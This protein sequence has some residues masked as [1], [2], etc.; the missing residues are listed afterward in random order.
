MNNPMERE[1][2]SRRPRNQQQSKQGM[3]FVSKV[4]FGFDIFQVVMVVVFQS[5]M[6][7]LGN[8]NAYNS[9]EDPGVGPGRRIYM[10]LFMGAVVYTCFLCLFAVKQQNFMEILA[11]LLQNFGFVTYGLIQ[12]Y[13]V[14]FKKIEF[15]GRNA[16]MPRDAQLLPIALTNSLMLFLLNAVFMYLSWKL[17]SEFGWKIYK[18]VRF[19]MRLRSV[20]HWYQLLSCLLKMEIL[21]WCMYALCNSLVLLQGTGTV[22]YYVNLVFVPFS[23]PYTALGICATKSEIKTLML[24]FLAITLGAVGFFIFKLYGFITDTCMGCKEF[25]TTGKD[26]HIEAI[27]HF[28][29]LGSL[30]LF[31]LVAILG[32]GYKVFRNFGL[33]LEEHFTPKE[34]GR[35]RTATDLDLRRLSH[36]IEESVFSV[37]SI[38]SNE[39][40]NYDELGES[41]NREDLRSISSGTPLVQD[42]LTVEVKCNLSNSLPNLTTPKSSRPASCPAFKDRDVKELDELLCQNSG[43]SVALTIHSGKLL[44]IAEDGK[45]VSNESAACKLKTDAPVSQHVPVHPKVQSHSRHQTNSNKTEPSQRTDD[46]RANF[47]AATTKINPLTSSSAGDDYVFR[48]SDQ[49]DSGCVDCSNELPDSMCKTFAKVRSKWELKIPREESGKSAAGLDGRNLGNNS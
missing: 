40:D 48:V 21:Y 42:L 45:T 47:A 16:T 44:S 30:N 15:P 25:H 26:I 6:I 1:L 49:R 9:P 13:H 3:S 41:F 33:G 5:L 7:A 32:V 11:F 28:V 19:N 46:S 8:Y 17:Y 34:T 14:G 20:Y 43:I 12:V 24:A 27:L 2:E 22:S 39:S 31:L 10:S 29:Y 23:I 4:F 18:R 36:Y 38:T 37:T 35:N